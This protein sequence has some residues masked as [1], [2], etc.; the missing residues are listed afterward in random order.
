M[1]VDAV[2]AHWADARAERRHLGVARELAAPKIFL[3]HRL[4]P[5]NPRRLPGASVIEDGS[6]LGTN[7]Q[8]ISRLQIPGGLLPAIGIAIVRS[9]FRGSVIR[10]TSRLHPGVG[11]GRRPGC[12]GD[13]HRGPALAVHVT[14]IR[15]PS[16]RSRGMGLT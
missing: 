7:A 5:G 4:F 14:L 13:R 15:Q 11:L 3:H 9:I 8:W 2:F 10:I 12:R 16:M 1:S 6:W